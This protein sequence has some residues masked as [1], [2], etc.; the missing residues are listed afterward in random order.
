[1]HSL[2]FEMIVGTTRYYQE[3]HYGSGSLSYFP[4]GF[5]AD[6]HLPQDQRLDVRVGYLQIELGFGARI[7][8]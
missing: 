7:V 1:M 3:Y 6:T 4:F 8:E 2:Y 5:G